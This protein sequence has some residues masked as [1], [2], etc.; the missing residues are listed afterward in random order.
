MSV[1]TRLAQ[2]VGQQARID[3]LERESATLRRALSR[4]VGETRQLREEI[5]AAGDRPGAHWVP[6]A[7]HMRLEHD[8]TMARFRI[9]ELEEA[10]RATRH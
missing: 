10:A 1:F 2:R 8:L 7:E 5:N 3:R 6:L 9:I 4:S